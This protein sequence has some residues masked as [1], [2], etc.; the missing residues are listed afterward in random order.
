MDKK[1]TV[2]DDTDLDR[3]AIRLAQAPEGTFQNTVA[4]ETL[5]PKLEGGKWYS[6]DKKNYQIPYEDINNKIKSFDWASILK[7]QGKDITRKMQVP[8]EIEMFLMENENKVQFI[9]DVLEGLDDYDVGVFPL[10]RWWDK[11][12]EIYEDLPALGSECFEDH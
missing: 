2:G 12:A 9:E 11:L 8:L 1:Y 5:G 10:D 6:Y 7:E 3:V 4:K